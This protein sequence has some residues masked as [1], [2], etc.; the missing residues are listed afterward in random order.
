MKVKIAYIDESPFYWTGSDNG[1]LRKYL[2]SN[3]HLARMAKY[4]ITKS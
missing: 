3:Y 1:Q 2:G 4:G